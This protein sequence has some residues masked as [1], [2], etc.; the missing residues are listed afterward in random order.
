MDVAAGVR[1][2]QR[3]RL[4]AAA[5]VRSTGVRPWARDAGDDLPGA[6]AEAVARADAPDGGPARGDRPARRCTPR[7]PRRWTGSRRAG[8][9]SDPARRAARP[10]PGQGPGVRHGPGRGAGGVRGERPVRGADPGH[11]APGRRHTGD[12]PAAL[13][14]PGGSGRPSALAAGLGLPG[15]WSERS[16][17][18]MATDAIGK[19]LVSSTLVVRRT[20]ASV[21]SRNSLGEP[22]RGGGLSPARSGKTMGPGS[23]AGAVGALA[24]RDQLDQNEQQEPPGRRGTGARLRRTNRVRSATVARKCVQLVVERRRLNPSVLLLPTSAPR[25]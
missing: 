16:F 3:P 8:A 14:G 1:A 13:R 19:S 21:R 7:S 11:P 18:P 17:S 22:V 4:R 24:S 10:A 6:V 12:L 5:S 25:A 20:S 15:P 9:R 2:G 23:G